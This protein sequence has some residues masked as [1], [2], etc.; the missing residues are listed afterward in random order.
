MLD[1]SS[2][3]EKHPYV[4]SLDDPLIHC[5]PTSFNAVALTLAYDPEFDQQ[6]AVG[7]G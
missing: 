5:I 4:V 7:P 2:G 1:Y 6:R 3:H